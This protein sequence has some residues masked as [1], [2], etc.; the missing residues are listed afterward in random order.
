MT[1]G[2]VRSEWAGT[3]GGPGLTQHAFYVSGG[4]EPTGSQAQSAVNAV[5]GLWEALKSLLPNEV[6]IQVS[7]TVDTY[8]DITAVLTGS[9]VV[10][11]PPPVKVGLGT[12][13]YAGGVGFKI[14]WNTGVILGGR[15]VVG[16]TY[17]VPATSTVFDIDG[18]LAASAISAANTAAANM[19]TAMSTGGCNLAVWTKPGGVSS[20]P[21]MTAVTSG[22]CRDKTAILRGR[23]D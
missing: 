16:R 20:V 7:P 19:L 4:S 15:R 1:V 8:D 21:G 13:T 14:D 3:S 2:I 22:T 12:G 18:T 23:R 11:T 9:Q 5:A 10:S 17:V 6:S